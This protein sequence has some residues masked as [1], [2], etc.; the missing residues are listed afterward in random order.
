MP[1]I[2]V[3]GYSV[4]AHEREKAKPAARNTRGQF[5]KPKPKPKPKPKAKPKTRTRAR[6]AT[7]TRKA[8]GP[9]QGGLF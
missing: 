6:K 7:R 3:K 9:A 5:S 8:T 2:K 1:K 4:I